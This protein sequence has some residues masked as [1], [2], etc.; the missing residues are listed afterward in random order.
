MSRGQPLQLGD[1]A[2]RAVHAGDVLIL[3]RSRGRLFHEIIRACKAAGLP[4]AGAD[5]LKVMAELAVKDIGALLSFLATQ[6]DNLSLATALRS[7]SSG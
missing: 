5:R 4:V 3:V 1:K 6:E 2:P 7:P